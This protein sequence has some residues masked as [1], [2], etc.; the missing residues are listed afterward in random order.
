MHQRIL[1]TGISGLVGTALRAALELAGA[2]VLGI[3]LRGADPERGDV[4]QSAQLASRLSGCTGIVHLAAVSRVIWAEREPQTC[5]STNVGGTRT[6]LEKSVAAPTRPWLI[7]AS[8]REVYGQ[9]ECLPVSEDAP[10]R[11]VN[12]YGR[13]KVAGEGLVNEARAIGLRAA[14]VRLSNVY[15]RTSDYADRVVPAF[16]RAAATNGHI[17]VDGSGHTFDF[18]HI[19]DTVRGL[20]ALVQLLAEGLAPPP[21]IHLLGGSPTALGELAQLAAELSIGGVTIEEAPPRSFDV[22]HFHG[23]PRRAKLELGWSPQVELPAGLRRLVDDYRA[24][25][26][27][28]GTFAS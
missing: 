21:P 8:S 5:W 18:T 19:D 13:S 20:V 11:P 17:R 9:P 25:L 4:R 2:E 28:K 6:V 23:D 24:E 7:F 27:A 3:D 12:I 22:A 15:G 16:A 14:I 1:I 10:S 26:A